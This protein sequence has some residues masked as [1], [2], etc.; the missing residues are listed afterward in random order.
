M[1]N[2]KF[3]DTLRSRIAQFPR[4]R[5]FFIEDLDELDQPLLVRH[6]LSVLVEE[7]FI[8]RLARGI[9]CYPRIEGE[10]GFRT[11]IPDAETVAYA[12]A[13]RE[14]VKIIPYGDV[15]AAHL[16]LTGTVISAHRYLTD[17]SPRVINLSSSEKIYFN[18]TSEV[19]MFAY[20]N[21]TVQM[22]CNAVRA[23]GKEF[24]E[25]EWRRRKTREI[26]GGVPEDVL[27]SDLRIAPVWVKDLLLEISEGR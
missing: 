25:E 7:K 8:L 13:A 21:A 12:L 14:N 4:G 20:T 10:Y 27:L 3:L 6:Y 19:K 5:I 17:G 18:H 23:L 11:V 26:M 15:A 16:G 1:D 9:Y 22:L 2:G 24:F